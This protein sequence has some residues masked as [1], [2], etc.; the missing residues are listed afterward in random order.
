MRLIGSIASRS[1]FGMVISPVVAMLGRAARMSRRNRPRRPRRPARRLP[2][3]HAGD[4]RGVR[5]A[6]GGAAPARLRPSTASSPARR[7]TG[8]SR[9]CSRRA[10]RARPH[11]GFAGHLDV[12]PPG[13]GWASDPFAPEIRGGLLHGRGVVDM[14]GGIAAFVAACAEVAEHQG[15]LSLIITGDEEGP[16]TY[17]TPAIMDW[18]AE[19]GDPPRH[20][21]DRRADLARRGSATSSRS[22]GA[23]RSTCGST[24]PG[25]QGHV[26]YPHRADNPVPKLGRRDRGAGGDPPRR[27]QRRLPALQPRDH[28]GRDGEQGDQRHPRL[29]RARSSTSASTI[30]SAAPIWSIWSAAPPRRR[31]PA[32]PSR[33]R[34][35]ARPS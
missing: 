13:E 16:A 11:F 20:D 1:S 3:R 25:V 5:R 8:R 6:G 32:R 15:T 2:E 7:R 35:R 33:R 14:K 4:R 21:P 31:R 17:G 9:I 19:R 24:V 22:A 34:S 28:R 12:V 29:R 10:A 30:C 18:M 26:A 27:R 23:A